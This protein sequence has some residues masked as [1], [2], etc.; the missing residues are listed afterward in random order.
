MPENIAVSLRFVQRIKNIFFGEVFH[1]NMKL[2]STGRVIGNES[3]QAFEISI[4]VITK[5]T[6]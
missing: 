1:K 5:F 4:K 6:G 2:S 3:L